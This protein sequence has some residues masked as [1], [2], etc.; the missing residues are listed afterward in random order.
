MSWT[1]NRK[2]HVPWLFH[3]HQKRY[4]IAAQTLWQT[5]DFTQSNRAR[6]DTN[7]L[8]VTFLEGVT[9]NLMRFPTT[10][11]EPI[12]STSDEMILFQTDAVPSA[13]MR[14]HAVATSTVPPIRCATFS[15]SASPQNQNSRTLSFVRSCLMMALLL[16]NMKI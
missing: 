14:R 8:R 13:K 4:L 15:R 2:K 12:L 11:R 7:L 6:R 9:R 1:I 10:S 16:T 3:L 5:R